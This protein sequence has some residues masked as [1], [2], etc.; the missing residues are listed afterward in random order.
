[1]KKNSV[2]EQFSKFLNNF[3]QLHI[4]L[5]LIEV[6]EHMPKYAKFLKIGD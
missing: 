2:D 1:M 6:L 5:S 4:N 3:E